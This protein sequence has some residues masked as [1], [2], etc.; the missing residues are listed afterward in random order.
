[1][2][3]P[4]QR[5]TGRCT[6]MK[7]KLTGSSHFKNSW[8]GI[9][10]SLGYPKPFKTGRCMLVRTYV[11]KSRK[12][13]LWGTPLYMH[14]SYLSRAASRVETSAVCHDWTKTTAIY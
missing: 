7:P 6:W 14:L 10:T 2:V 12:L 11:Q 3:D 5:S 13:H 9:W 1:M 8:I 4:K